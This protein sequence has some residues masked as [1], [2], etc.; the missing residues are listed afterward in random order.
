MPI[1][2]FGAVCDTSALTD[3]KTLDKAQKLFGNSGLYI[4]SPTYS[5]LSRSKLIEVRQQTVKYSLLNELVRERKI[6]PVHLPELYDEISRQI[7]FK[8]DH[9][10]ALTDLRGLLLA[11]HLQLP[12]LTFDDGLIERI[13][14]E[15]GVQ[16]MRRFEAHAN[17]LALR[18]ALELYR[19]LSFV[20]GK[21]F[22]KQLENGNT[23]PK[24]V[25]KIKKSNE[26]NFKATEKSVQKISQGQTNPGTLQLQ[27][28]AWDTIPSIREYY[29]QNIFPDK[30]IRQIC[31]K[32]VL[33]I[34][35]P[36]NSENS[37]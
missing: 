5:W 12:I 36:A 31:E 10:V 25:Q 7:M 4:P 15:I 18:D 28:L 29:E 13:S 24:T 16:T 34:A 37:S 22:R 32:N 19:E 9:N 33:L 8:T 20:S 2:D 11:A 17:W 27:Y 1:Q 26:K 30:I 35:K 3:R 14:E 6:Y 21:Q 23:F